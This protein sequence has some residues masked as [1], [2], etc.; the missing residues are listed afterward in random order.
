M[1]NH[2]SES[3]TGISTTGGP[4]AYYGACIAFS[5]EAIYAAAA[6]S[7]CNIKT[8]VFFLYTEKIEINTI[9]WLT[10]YLCLS[11]C[12]IIIPNTASCLYDNIGYSVAVDALQ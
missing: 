7:N 3:R 6:V 12:S 1:N 10:V 2:I 11:S 4:N 5:T 8:A 9:Q